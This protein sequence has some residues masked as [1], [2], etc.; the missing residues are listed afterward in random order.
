MTCNV[1]TLKDAG[2]DLA[3]TSPASLNMSPAGRE[4]TATICCIRQSFISVPRA[5]LLNGPPGV[6]KTYSVGLAVKV[7]EAQGPIKLVS[8]LGSDL[9][10]TGS[11]PSEAAKALQRQ[12]CNAARFCHAENHVSLIFIDECEAL[13][14]S[15]VVAAMF[16]SLLD[17]ISCST[18][19]GWQRIVVVAATNRIDA[20]PLW[21]RRPGRLDREIALGPPNAAV[22][23]EIIQSLIRKSTLQH[24]HAS[25][26]AIGLSE[27]AEACVGYVPADLAALVRRATLL[28]I[29]EGACQVTANL[30]KR[31]MVDV[32]ASV[33]K[34]RN[35]LRMLAY[36]FCSSS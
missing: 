15:D 25:D 23:L 17:Q 18:D 8:L 11:H 34:Y 16:G 4:L 6:G 21:L 30:L 29:Q 13:L 19:K 7:S 24:Y 36:E 3:E 14:S 20:V 5:F 31:A 9:L 28:A 22:R 26:D 27:V 32:G 1:L 35:V 12:F 2:M 33:S 10:S